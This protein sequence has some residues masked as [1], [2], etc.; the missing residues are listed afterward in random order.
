MLLKAVPAFTKCLKIILKL[1]K[2]SSG[3]EANHMATVN[4]RSDK[5]KRQK[6]GQHETAKNRCR[7]YIHVLPVQLI[8]KN[9]YVD[10]RRRNSH[11]GGGAT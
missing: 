6:A 11:M 7:R 1:A 4:L 8:I 10:L 2:Y 5:A 9:G 3:N